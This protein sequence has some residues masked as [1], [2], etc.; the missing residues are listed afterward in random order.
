MIRTET[1]VAPSHHVRTAAVTS[2]IAAMPV[3]F[4]FQLLVSDLGQTSRDLVN[5]SACQHGSCEPSP[6]VVRTVADLEHQGSSCR[7]KP[8]LTDSVVFEWKTA[9]VTVV[10][11]ATSIRA[12][13]NHEGWVR[14][15]CMPPR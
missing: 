13:S 8:A 15:Y 4:G 9:E 6:A 3:V 11:F 14:Q 12:L 1:V 10:D 5:E 2:V 7:T